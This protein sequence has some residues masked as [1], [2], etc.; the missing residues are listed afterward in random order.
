MKSAY[1]FLFLKPSRSEIVIK[2][3][4]QNKG[5]FRNNDFW[6]FKENCENGWFFL[7]KTKTPAWSLYASKQVIFIFS[8]SFSDFIQRFTVFPY[9]KN[10]LSLIRWECLWAK[11]PLCKNLSCVDSF[12]RMNAFFLNILP[13]LTANV[14]TSDQ[15]SPYLLQ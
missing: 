10:T 2:D 12:Q 13:M 3:Q 7:T 9:H 14:H 8:C 15:C 6:S 5:Y 11:E 4:D 1:A